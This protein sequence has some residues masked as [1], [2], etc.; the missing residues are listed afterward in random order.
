[1]VQAVRRCTYIHTCIHT[2]IHSYIQTYLVTVWAAQFS[3]VRVPTVATLLHSSTISSHH[4][5]VH[6]LWRLSFLLFGHRQW[7][8]LCFHFIPSHFV[9]LWAPPVATL[10]HI[11]VDFNATFLCGRR[12]CQRG[13]LF[14]HRIAIMCT[15]TFVK[16]GHR[17]WRPLSFHHISSHHCSGHTHFI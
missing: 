14:C 4:F 12:L 2:Y 10:L 3:L 5:C 15:F 7:R 16:I 11:S 9:F 6:R 1:M 13:F 8:P 17:Q